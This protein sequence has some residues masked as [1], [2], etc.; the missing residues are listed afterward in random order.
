[1]ICYYPN[2]LSCAGGNRNK[3]FVWK[4]GKKDETFLKKNT[5]MSRHFIAL[6]PYE[7]Q[8]VFLN[9]FT[10]CYGGMWVGVNDVVCK[11]T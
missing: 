10:N 9:E 7:F 6:T 1:M 5:S 2:E 4:E 8:A 3:S 11:R